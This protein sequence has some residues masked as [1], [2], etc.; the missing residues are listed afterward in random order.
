MDEKKLTLR[1]VIQL[2]GFILAI[3]GAF[4]GIKQEVKAVESSLAKQFAI[5]DQQRQTDVRILELKM[6]QIKL[7]LDRIQARINK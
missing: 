7:E 3:A 2:G 4:F 5:L 1:D 6:A